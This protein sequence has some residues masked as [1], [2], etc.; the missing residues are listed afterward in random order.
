MVQDAALACPRCS[1]A[2]RPGAPWCTQCFLDVRPAPARAAPR[3]DPR[4][5]LEGA[6]W[7]CT[8][9]GAV[10]PLSAVACDG[11]G[12]GF[13][14][15]AHASGTAPLALPVVGDLGR[16]SSA[17]RLALAAGTVVL[18]MLLTALLGLLTG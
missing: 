4:P 11:C 10:N 8:A 13:L 1:A 5:H 14:D 2:L 9:C 17:Q 7:P 16:L 18:V 15:G 3:P 12:A 6:Q